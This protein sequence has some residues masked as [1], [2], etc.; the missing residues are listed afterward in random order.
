MVKW[1][2]DMY[3]LSSKAGTGFGLI[4]SFPY[5]LLIYCLIFKLNLGSDQDFSFSDKIDCPRM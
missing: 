3:L 2:S 1:H 5:S 4:Y